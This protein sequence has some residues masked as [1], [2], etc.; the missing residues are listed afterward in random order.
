[1]KLMKYADSLKKPDFKKLLYNSPLISSYVEDILIK[2]L[3]LSDNQWN[4]V[5]EIFNDIKY[6]ITMGQ[7]D[8]NLSLKDL[9]NF[10]YQLIP[11]KSS[12]LYEIMKQINEQFKK[13][14]DKLNLKPY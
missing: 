10:Y 3:K 2:S 5:L 6:I 12:E 13:I 7:V 11:Y 9:I 1:M 8:T 14:A 4:K